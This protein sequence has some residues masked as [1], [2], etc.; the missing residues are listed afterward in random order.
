MK[1]TPMKTDQNSTD[2][3]ILGEQF[4]AARK[5]AGFS[6]EALAKVFSIARSTVARW[7][8]GAPPKMALLAIDSLASDAKRKAEE[9]IGN[10]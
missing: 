2:Q 5:A 1:P 3:N 9:K 7:E 4:A 6:Q 8:A 10:I